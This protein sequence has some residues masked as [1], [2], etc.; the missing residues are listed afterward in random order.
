[1]EG[2][3][4]GQEG[5][6]KGGGGGERKGK[7]KRRV[8]VEKKEL[9]ILKKRRLGR[10]HRGRGDKVMPVLEVQPSDKHFKTK[11]MSRSLGT[12]WK[13]MKELSQE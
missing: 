8:V 13:R 4:R 11:E 9:D 5:G 10:N 12:V 6:K 7:K 3:G 2:E 1:L